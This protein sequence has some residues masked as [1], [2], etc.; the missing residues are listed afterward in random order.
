[1]VNKKV[2]VFNNK[3]HYNTARSKNMN[4]FYQ[5]LTVNTIKGWQREIYENKWLYTATDLFVS[6]CT[7][8][9]VGM[10]VG[11]CMILGIR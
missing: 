5:E 3:K 1:M 7:G 8:F 11:M 6:A 2:V 10:L 9:L 4:K